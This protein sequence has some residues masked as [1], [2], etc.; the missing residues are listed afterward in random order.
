MGQLVVRILPGFNYFFIALLLGN[1][2]AAE[3]FGNLVYRSLGVGDQFRFGFR[4]GHIGNRH[5]HGRPGGILIANSLYIV[6]GHRRLGRPVDV[7][8]FFQDLLKLLFSHVEIHFQKQGVFL[9]RPVHKPQILGDN[10]VENKTANRRLHKPALHGSAFHG[11]IH[12]HLNPGVEGDYPVFISQDSF[13][14][15]LKCLPFTQAPRT[16]LGQ[17]INPQ[18]HILGRHGHQAAV[19]RLQQIIGGQQQEPAFCLGLHGQRQMHRHLVAVKIRVKGRTYQGMELDGLAFHQ[20]RLKSL[21]AKPV[22]RRGPV[23]HH[24]M[25]LDNLFQYVP[26]FGL[27]ALYHLLRAFNVMG[28]AVLHQLLHHKRFKKFNG[29]LFGEA[30]LVYF[31]FRSHHDNGTARI[32]YPL[33]QQVLAEPALLPL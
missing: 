3:V 10:L 29:H 11:L 20:N 2:A 13:V 26:Y 22:Q 32:V 31:Q 4:D 25:F 17:V 21:D 33:A 1:Q 24:R 27:Q 18:H 6:Q 15:I 30:A 12:P 5:G 14:Y 9:L 16:F 28:S 19:G 7:K 8:H 23:Q